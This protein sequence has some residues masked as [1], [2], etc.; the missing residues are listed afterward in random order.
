MWA[1]PFGYLV[2]SG[3]HMILVGGTS[4]PA[5]SLPMHEILGYMVDNSRGG[6]AI[7]LKTIAKTEA[8]V[9][10]YLGSEFQDIELLP[11]VAKKTQMFASE[12]ELMSLLSNS[13]TTEEES[14]AEAEVPESLSQPTEAEMPEPLPVQAEPETPE[15][16]ADMQSVD[17]TV[18][19][20]SD[21]F[22]IPAFGEDIDSTKLRVSTLESALEQS[23]RMCEE[24]N[25][26]LQEV[27]KMQ[28]DQLRE[29]QVAADNKLA[30]A[31]NVI[32]GL[33][34]TIKSTQ[35]DPSLSWFA[36]YSSYAENPRAL[37]KEGFSEEERIAL[38]E[39]KSSLHIFAAGPGDS[40]YGMLKE[41]KALMDGGKSCVVVDFTNDLYLASSY[42]MR[43]QKNSLQLLS[44]DVNPED[45][46]SLINNSFTFVST[47]YNDIALL[48]VNWG[49]FLRKLDDYANGKPIIMLFGYMGSFNVRHVISKLALVGQL[50]LFVRCNPMILNT[51]YGDVKFIPQN[52]M[53]IVALDYIDVVKKFL[54][55]ISKVYKVTAFTGSVDWK[56]IGVRL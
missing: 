2:E 40:V 55:E 8:C 1:I 33:Q 30:E 16:P 54:E 39:M 17:D 11:E 3:E 46:V 27:Y 25:T 15:S 14:P 49:S 41:A 35:I 52:R 6:L 43:A 37:S 32:N 34:D 7:K 4:L 53:K 56:K 24:L 51:F 44:E 50:S 19:L 23:Q 20:P 5:E 26:T 21:M 18:Q 36:H 10:V 48:R 31:Q 12:E 38:G 29:I 28:E 45:C 42:H 47:V 9:A 13:N 22:V